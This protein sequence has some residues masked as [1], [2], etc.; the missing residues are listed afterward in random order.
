MASNT[1]IPNSYRARYHELLGEENKVFLRYCQMPL[2]KAIRVNTLKTDVKTLKKRLEDKGFKL[3]PIPWTPV[4]FWIE[5]GKNVEEAL[6]NTE[7]HFLGYFYIQ[8]ASSMIPP[9]VLD[10]KPGELVLD[11]AAAPGSKTTQMSEMMENKGV[12]I[13]NDPNFNRLKALK[14]NI[15]KSGSINVVVT[16][17]DG[18]K[19]HKWGIKFDKILLDAPCSS[20]GTV[21]KD[22]K[23]LSRW[24]EGLVRSLSKMQKKLILS[25]WDSL[26]D[27]GVMVYSTCTL[28]PEENEEVVDFL[29][30]NKEGVAVEKISVNGLKFR[31]GVTKWRDKKYSDEVRDCARIWPQDNDSEGFF[32]CRLRKV[33]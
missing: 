26:K 9:I 4:G 10:P 6:G 31:E 21:R 8:E 28:S 20:E 27:D 22:W 18:R 33:E 24:N 19:V 23:A 29:L 25:A 2:R 16:N 12:I 15:E 7:E 3:T 1:I 11:V 13:A 5:K 17:R 32:V 14:F 30:K